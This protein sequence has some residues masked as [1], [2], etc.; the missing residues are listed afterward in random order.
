MLRRSRKLGRSSLLSALGVGALL[1]SMAG[2]A[3]ASAETP[4]AWWRLSVHASPT[5]L[6]PET[7]KNGEVVPG[8]GTIVVTAVNVGDGTLDGSSTPLALSDSLPAGLKATAIDG[9]ST[10]KPTVRPL[11]CELS[12]V[13]CIYPE[14][15]LPYQLVEMTISV[16]VTL[17]PTAQTEDDVARLDVY[18][19]EQCEEVEENAG[20]FGDS[21]CTEHLQQGKGGHLTGHFEKLPVGNVI[22]DT[23]ATQSL[24][25]SAEPVRFG[26]QRYAVTPEEVGGSADIR[27]GSH[28]FQFTTVFG[29]NQTLT[30]DPHTHALEPS[31]PELVKNLEF[32]LPPGLAGNAAKLPQCTSADFAVGLFERGTLA[33]N[34]CPADTAVGL[35]SVSIYEPN[36]LEFATITVPVFNLVPAPGEPAR[37]GFDPIRVPVVLDTKV[38]TGRNYE[39]VVTV[40]NADQAAVLLS[41][42]VTFWGSPSD[43]RH[44]NSRGWECA[45]DAPG[46]HCSA[47]AQPV[48]AFLTLPTSCKTTLQTTVQGESWQG[49]V[50]TQ[51]LV[52]EPLFTS[53][54]GESLGPETNCG[55]LPFGPKI[56]VTPVQEVK[57]T[58][59][60]HLPSTTTAATPTGLKVDVTVP[61]A[62]T[63]DSE[64][65]GEADVRDTTTTLP[66]GVLASPSA[67]NGLQACTESQVGY[68]KTNEEKGNSEGTL[69]FSPSQA[70]CPDASKIGVVRIKTPLLKN[71]AEGGGEL[72][73]GVYLAKQEANPFHSL[74]AMYIVAEDKFA[75][76]LV[77]LAGK[78]VAD[79][80]TGQLVTT[81]PNTPQTPFSELELELFGG[82]HASVTTPATCGTYTTSALFTP[83]SETAAQLATSS[84]GITGE[85]NGDGCPSSQPFAPTFAADSTSSNAQ[86][87]T[88]FELT[89]QRPDEDQAL[90]G[91]AVKLPPGIA[92]ML[93]SVTLCG[94]KPAEEGTCGPESQI[95]TATATTGLG[96]DPFTVTGGRVYLTG[97]YQGAPFGLSIVTPAKAGPFDFGNVVT[98]SAIN[99]DRNTAAI[100][101]TTTLPTMVNTR[102]DSGAPLHQTGVPVQLKQVHVVINR[103]N[104]QFNPTN[105][106]PAKIE[107]T[108]TGAQGATA[109]VSSNFQTT[110][111][112]AL[113]FHPVF[114]A[115]A[116]G[117]TSKVDGASLDVK[118]VY[119]EGAYA[120][121]AK[122][123]TD[124][125]YALPS[126][127]TTI[128]KACPDTTFEANPA[129][130]GEGSVIGQAIVH[131]PVFKN[132]LMGPAY[133]VSHGNRAFP[134]I[135]VVLQG[136][137]LTLVLDGQTDIKKGI[138][139]TSFEAVPDA[140]VETFELMLPEGPHSALAA[141][142]NLCKPTTTVTKRV[143]VAR[144]IHGHTVHVL[145]SVTKTV[146]EALVIPTTLT[147]QN[148]A[149]LKQ[150]TPIAVTGCG[151]VKSFKAK[152]KKHKK[153]AK[154]KS[155]KK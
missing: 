147:A 135:E 95:G 38:R 151:G 106:N 41:S 130:C 112:S 55:A 141:N 16:E 120:N 143:K 111:C 62:S 33:Q 87:F 148:G 104:F 9:D 52:E 75:G 63:L 25:V 83:W 11:H 118:I 109:A 48:P 81:F 29:L 149:V 140:P 56:S 68:E 24:T 77:K 67:A 144:R 73:G 90:T 124:L 12:A 117:Q 50:L 119:P 94:E 153:K 69:E 72:E 154:H 60:E 155:K 26:V 98:Q 57:L 128:Q 116:S 32:T 22:A 39:S 51:G 126:R 54:Q 136:E 80:S 5:N 114:T 78:I 74:L 125:P 19:T 137:G 8:K 15:V 49:T 105:C 97:P 36:F 14:S 6:Q 113:A 102:S 42:Q 1:A 88:N 129:S 99:V 3:P 92:G 64:A 31:T 150:N 123:V 66:A 40:S 115:S 13:R 76:V 2:A 138:T 20:N 7:E 23:K 101:I 85:P 34:A 44:D 21:H 121:I 96:P 79:P 86:Q 47:S 27:A 127:L 35:A 107:G 4:S 132:P 30:V 134:D 17:P 89:I 82:P 139:K 146:P 18:E 100:T 110:N 70:S 65:L 152:A 122:S 142:G 145:K 58:E 10:G 45:E 61:Q 37:F 103:P 46:S 131:T 28:P 133:L 43:P 108:L 53:E 93:K 91:V 71:K 59:A 84:F